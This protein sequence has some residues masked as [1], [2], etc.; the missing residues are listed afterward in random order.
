MSREN[1]EAARRFTEAV[2]A[3]DVEAAVQLV[4]PD[5][6]FVPLRAATEGAFMGHEGL[7]RFLADTVETFET[8]QVDYP[9]IRDLGDRLLM[10]GSIRVRGRA[11]GVETDIPSAA[12]AEVRDGLFSRYEDYG[13]ARLALEAAGLGSE[14]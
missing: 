13:E 6:V 5:L 3:R 10:I 7:R 12:I 8:F 14:R 11:S 9:D 4:Q 2:N 1:V